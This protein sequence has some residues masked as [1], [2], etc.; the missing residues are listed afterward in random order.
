MPAPHSAPPRVSLDGETRQR[1]ER[2]EKRSALR[3]FRAEG[4]LLQIFENGR[5][6]VARGLGHSR[7]DRTFDIQNWP[8]ERTTS[9]C[10]PGRM[11]TQVPGWLFCSNQAQVSVGALVYPW[12]ALFLKFQKTP[13]LA[14]TLLLKAHF[15]I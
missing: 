12:F 9:K 10:K 1:V 13:G 11:L 8:N 15:A 2:K 3:D 4:H 6:R 14:L 5:E 7:R